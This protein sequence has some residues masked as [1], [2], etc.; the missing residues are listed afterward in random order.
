MKRQQLIWGA[1][2]TAAV[3]GVALW[4]RPTPHD[5]DVVLVARDLL[6]VTIDEPGVC[7]LYT[8]ASETRPESV[9]RSPGAREHFASLNT[10]GFVDP[11]A[12]TKCTV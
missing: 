10:F 4:L 12:F 1:T 5:V 2:L 7:L 11:S 8:S 9:T 6:R 3:A